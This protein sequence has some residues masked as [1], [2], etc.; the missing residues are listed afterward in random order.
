MADEELKKV[1]PYTKLFDTKGSFKKEV[2]MDDG[3]LTSGLN[4]AL[5]I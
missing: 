4:E 5:R 1:N 2:E 3:S